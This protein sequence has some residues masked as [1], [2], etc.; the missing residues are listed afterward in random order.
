M[1]L[2]NLWRELA[3]KET[4]NQESIAIIQA[5]VVVCMERVIKFN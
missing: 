4:K 2:R 5:K 3:N 1:D